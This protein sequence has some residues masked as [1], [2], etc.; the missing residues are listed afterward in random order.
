[1]K[2]CC[3]D[4]KK[5]FEGNYWHYCPYCGKKFAIQMSENLFDWADLKKFRE[6]AEKE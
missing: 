1:M 5:M 6:E 2:F 3:E 4:M